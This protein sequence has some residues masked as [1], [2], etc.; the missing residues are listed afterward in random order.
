MPN[1]SQ[2][3]VL[4]WVS[5]ESAS[6]SVLTHTLSRRYGHLIS[7]L[8]S[9]IA[10]SLDPKGRQGNGDLGHT[11]R[12]VST[13]KP[14]LCCHLVQKEVASKVKELGQ[15][16]KNSFSGLTVGMGRAATDRNVST[17]PGRKKK[18]AS[19]PVLVC[20]NV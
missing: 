10:P 14:S 8:F 17:A 2:A 18:N 15:G 19:Q 6:Q 11:L 20:T 4:L 1:G 13:K 12:T 16:E 9:H 7:I 5:G 3:P